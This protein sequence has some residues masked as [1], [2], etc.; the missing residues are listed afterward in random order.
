MFIFFVYALH[1]IHISGEQNLIA[2]GPRAFITWE[3]YQGDNNHNA[4][5]V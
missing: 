3:H 1:N 2:I 5:F 4:A